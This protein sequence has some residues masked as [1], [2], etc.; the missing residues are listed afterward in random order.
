MWPME[1]QARTSTTLKPTGSLD[2]RRLTYSLALVSPASKWVFPFCSG[3]PCFA[4]FSLWKLKNTNLPRNSDSPVL[5]LITTDGFSS[6]L[7]APPLLLPTAA[8]L[9]TAALAALGAAPRGLRP[10]NEMLAGD[11]AADARLWGFCTAVER[12]EEAAAAA[13]IAWAFFSDGGG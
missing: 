5:R 4:T 10:R 11:T 7:I 2:L 12:A 9:L 6:A 8:V 3:S 13:A 1:P